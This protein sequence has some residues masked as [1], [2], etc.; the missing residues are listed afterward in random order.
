MA[1]VSTIRSIVIAHPRVAQIIRVLVLLVALGA[2][3]ELIL[4][5][6][7]G[8]K[9]ADLAARMDV[10]AS[11]P[12]SDSAFTLC[13]G[14]PEFM[15]T[16]ARDLATAEESV[17]VQTL[18]FE[19]DPAG[20]ALARA[21]VD[22]PAP[23]KTLII[24][25]YARYV[26]SDRLITPGARLFDRDFYAEVQGTRSL[27]EN[28]IAAGIDVHFARPL[29]G[30]PQTLAV[31]DHK[32]I[33]TID[34]RIA[35]VGGINFSAH[36]FL[37]HDLMVRMADPEVAGWLARDVQSTLAGREQT[38]SAS[39]DGVDLHI[40]NGT[41]AGDLL[42][43]VA[44]LI[45]GARRSLYLECPYVTEPFHRLLAEARARG[46][47]VTVVTSERSN[48]LFMRRSIIHGCG[49]GD[50]DLRFTRGPMTHVKA[51]L[52]D[53]ETLVMGSANFDFLSFSLQPEVVAVIRDAGCVKQFRQRVEAPA[54]AQSTL[55][56][57]E[58]QGLCEHVS[59][60]A[61][62]LARPVL[63]RVARR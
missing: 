24:D 8:E 15:A 45:R 31:R 53:G 18:A 1:I 4:G 19:D 29:S 42:A 27:I 2:A 58:G 14:G 34:D 16:L 26:I 17:C 11:E 52:I 3:A 60:R 43:P 9:G 23:S 48:R 22:C 35:Y 46:V 57:G 20:R 10:A 7:V 41:P 54:L 62:H 51:L 63:G 44:Q 6:A 30:R 61:L 25:S 49:C 56:E 38:A 28:L 40:G 39:F 37:W 5:M 32:K 12:A 33:V 47:A 13:V 36:N 21:L 50:V 55:H 59:H